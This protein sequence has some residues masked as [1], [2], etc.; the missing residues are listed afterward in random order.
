MHK[1]I[2]FGM[3]VAIIEAAVL[4]GSSTAYAQQIEGALQ[5]PPLSVGEDAQ[6]PPPAR[7]VPQTVSPRR[8]E[9]GVSGSSQLPGNYPYRVHPR[10]DID[11]LPMPP[12]PLLGAS[13]IPLPT[14]GGN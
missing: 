4:I 6:P 3:L 14:A 8:T 2:G 1:L 13:P 9:L 5:Y 12:A 10:T 7:M 11:R